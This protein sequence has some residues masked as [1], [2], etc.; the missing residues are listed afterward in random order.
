M[1]TTNLQQYAFFTS[2]ID[3]ALLS[4]ATSV[5]IARDSKAS[6]VDTITKGFSGMSPGA[7]M[8]SVSL[9]CAIPTAGIE[10][11]PGKV[12]KGVTVVDIT[13]A[14]AGKTLSTKGFITKDDISYSVNGE[15]KIKIEAVCEYA[16][17][18]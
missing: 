7:A 16:D 2:Y 13:I 11:N 3:G 1:A 10:Y 15:A 6:Q 4:E 18:V 12:I 8:M 14:G 9:E 17:W 5:S